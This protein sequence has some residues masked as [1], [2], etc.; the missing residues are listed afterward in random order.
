MR[1]LLLFDVVITIAMGVF[2]YASFRDV[3]LF[4]AIVATCVCAALLVITY[5]A[6]K[7]HEE[8]KREGIIQFWKDQLLLPAKPTVAVPVGGYYLPEPLGLRKELLN[9]K[10]DSE[11]EETLTALIDC[12]SPW[13]N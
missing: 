11:S 4:A 2:T 12:P 10:L 5:S 9:P 13:I 6:T 3:P 7:Q 1:V 8:A